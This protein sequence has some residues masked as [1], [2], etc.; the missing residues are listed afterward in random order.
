[1]SDGF[2]HS[3][4]VPRIYKI[5]ANI[6]RCVQEQGA[7]LKGLIYEKK[8]PNVS[9]IYA[10]SVN[11]LKAGLQLDVLLEKTQ[12][13]TE[14]PR[15]DP[16]LT[17]VLITELLWGKKH[18]HGPSKPI[19]TILSYADLLQKELENLESTRSSATPRKVQRPR[20][21]RVN[22]LL[23]SIREAISLFKEEGWKLLTKSESYSSYLQSLA[24]LSEPYFLQDFH[25]PEVLAFP[26][27]TS[28]YDHAGYRNGKLILQ[29]KA[30]CLPA[31]LLDPKEN[32]HVVDLCAA[33][34]MKSTHLAAK[35]QNKG[36]IYAVEIDKRRFETLR[37][38]IELTHSSCVEP[39]NQDALTF[40]PKECHRVHY[41]L[42]DPSCS[43]SGIIDRPKLSNVDGEV[44]PE[45]LQ[46]L[47]SIQVYLLRYALLNFPNVKRVIYSTCSVHPEE[48]EKVIDEVLGN[49]GDAYRLVSIKDMLKENWL[50]FSS[51]EYQC[52]D[53]C[54]Y[55]KPDVDLCNG[56][57]VAMFERNFEVPLPECKRK[58]G[59][60]NLDRSNL[61]AEENNI[62][63]NDGKITKKVS[64]KKKKRGKKKHK[65]S[66]IDEQTDET[67]GQAGEFEKNVETKNGKVDEPG[68]VI[69]NEK[70]TLN[71]SEDTPQTAKSK[72]SK[73]KRKLNDNEDASQVED[74]EKNKE[75][76]EICDVEEMEQDEE[77]SSTSSKK[78]KK[79]KEKKEHEEVVEIDDD[80][81][82]SK[83][84]QTESVKEKRK[85][86]NKKVI[87]IDNDE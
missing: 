53:K 10:L 34:G 37:E 70:A 73:R 42:V 38:Q 15:L 62:T 60:A 29:D 83:E 82:K 3:V 22:T 14:Q 77:V 55:S 26:S 52:G 64:R 68:D 32:S 67:S 39:H 5:T 65:S 74:N 46:N 85:K 61:N 13:L 6:V 35:L 43:G 71:E 12:I 24:L 33:P 45:R 66:M 50:N 51:P 80:V 31:H 49:V 8:H 58:G 19:Q 87:E 21:V 84:G 76:I 48:N 78:K 69:D 86:K 17:R 75:T 41:V 54:L 7:S 81:K 20:Y 36:T 25:V 4:K 23:L 79:K 2:V 30:S 57:F 18:L 27:S 56:F 40:N 47:Q 1:M 59:N 44:E 11:T 9:G 28:F 63:E 72:K 16:W